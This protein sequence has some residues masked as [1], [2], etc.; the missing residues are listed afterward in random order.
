MLLHKYSHTC[1]GQPPEGSQTGV[2]KC[3][4]SPSSLTFSSNSKPSH[5]GTA[6]TRARGF[7]HVPE[8][9]HPHT[10]THILRSRERCDFKSPLLYSLEQEVGVWAE[11][12]STV[13]YFP[14]KDTDAE[15]TH[16]T[17]KVTLGNKYSCISSFKPK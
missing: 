8:R 17:H 5:V 10:H 16:R 1:Q 11:V 14:A 15:H 4:R 13:G 6:S 3:H 2:N 9:A 7:M 12:I